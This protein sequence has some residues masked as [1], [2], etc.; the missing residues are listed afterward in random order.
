MLYSGFTK[1]VKVSGNRRYKKCDGD[2]IFLCVDPNVIGRRIDKPI[3]VD[4]EDKATTAELDYNIDN[5]VDYELKTRDSRIGELTNTATSIENKYTTNEEVKK[6]YSNY[7]SLLRIYQG[8]EIDFVKTGVRWQMNAGLRKHLKQLPYF[9]LYNYPKKMGTY[10][11]LKKLNKNLPLKEQ[12]PLNAFHSPSP[13]NELCDYINTWEKKKILWDNSV[14]DTSCLIL[15]N[16]LPTNDLSIQ[17]VIK[18]A[19]REFLV[20]FKELIELEQSQDTFFSQTTELLVGKYKRRL[21]EEL[22]ELSY[23]NIANYVIMLSYRNPSISKTFA[24][25]GYGD[26]ILKNLRNNSP[27]QKHCKIYETPYKTEQSYEYL[28]KYYIMEEGADI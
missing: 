21:E 9:L 6:L 2:A 3:I 15:N 16:A 14:V 28:G 27:A 22:P 11:K 1:S 25:M 8:K 20:D 24:W 4:V 10:K 7:A 17:K 23:D 18:K 19:M 13:M 26:I 12:L 5:I